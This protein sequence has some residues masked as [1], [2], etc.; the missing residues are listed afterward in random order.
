M[1]SW[2]ARV[3]HALRGTVL[4]D[5]TGLTLAPDWRIA[6]AAG[7][8]GALAAVAVA[9]L[10][11]RNRSTLGGRGRLLEIA[12]NNMTQ[13]VIMFDRADRIVVCNER[14]LEIYGLPPEIIKPGATVE[15]TVALRA[16]FG[17]LP[18]SPE[19]Y[20]EELKAKL[21]SGEV[22]SFVSELPDGR[23]IAV[24]NRTVPGGSYWIGTHHDITER[25][26]AERRGALLGEQEARRAVLEEAIAW[27]RQSVEGV[28]QTVGDSVASLKATAAALS[29]SSS[30]TSAHTVGAVQTSNEAFDSV[31]VAATAA[32][33]M[34]K[35][36]GEI[37][38]Q[39]ARAAGV[40]H[41]ATSQAQSTN[42]DIV[43]LAEAAQKI[44]DVIKLIHSV[45][46]QTNLLAL[47]ATI[48]A[49]RA[50]AAGKGFA[51]VASEVKALAVQ[52]AKATDVIAGQIA[53]VQASTQS[54]VDAIRGISGRVREIEQ[55]TAAIA[56]AVEQQHNA[57]SRISHNVATAAA[58]TKSV[59]AVLQ[60]V[61]AATA[62]MHSSADTVLKA[63]GS[64]EQA[65]ENLRASVDGF[66][67]KVA[68]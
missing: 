6:A 40:V 3:R 64:V 48:E 45:A 58:G 14:Y 16:K 26:K 11:L 63:S 62:D 49:A 30:D 56:A 35:S 32:A 57:T 5:L 46:G 23:S 36:I 15:Q 21:A 55:F 44:D 10:L 24:V 51:V 68:S 43:G 38:R 18:S 39:L 34:I 65:A 8:C 37:N 50:G 41:A 19:R 33:E 27:F 61:A 28:L 9:Y 66:L 4:S 42:E 22:M 25:R 53:G 7:F 20:R 47:N 67:R 31:E 54:A 59:V 52:T 60:R 12:L 1:G 29:A 17:S 2:R 13:G